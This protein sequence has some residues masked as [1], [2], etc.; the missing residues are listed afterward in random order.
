MEKVINTS[1]NEN[2]EI[3]NGINKSYDE[4]FTKPIIKIGRWTLL[5]A[6]VL[7][8]LPSLYLAIRYGALPPIGAILTGWLLI[9]S[10]YAPYYFIE[11]ISY[12]PILGMAGTY[13]SFLAGEIGNMRLP[14]SAIA[15]DVLKV[16]QG[17]KKAE[18]VSTLAIAGSVVTSLVAGTIAVAA[19]SFILSVLPPFVVKA[20]DFVLP[21][22]FGAMYAMFAV[23]SPRYGAFALLLVLFLSGV[24]KGLPVYVIIP[25]VIFSTIGLS[26][27]EF[28][29]K[30][31]SN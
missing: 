19:G 28:K 20:F 29:K 4:N 24:V 9:A 6:V 15:Q 11:P 10:I 17:S 23:K 25:V 8:L 7:C 16:E 2:V 22:I 21:S 1:C 31:K 5:S 12:F 30:A 18:L 27:F 14:C 13:M 3:V 26:F